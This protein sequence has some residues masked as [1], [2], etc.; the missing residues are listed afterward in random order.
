MIARRSTP[1]QYRDWNA[2]W[3]APFGHTV[4]DA[5]T[6][7]C[8]L[9]A[10][11]P[12]R[13][14]LFG[15]QHNSATRIFEYPWAFHTARL[16]PGYKVMDVGAG[17]SGFQFVLARSGCEVV[18][19]DP[20]PAGDQRWSSGLNGQQIW[21]TTDDHARL[22]RLLGTDVTLVADS[23]QNYSPD[24]RLFDR[25][26]CLSVLEH[27]DGNEANAMLKRMAELLVPGGLCV[28]TVDLFLD[29]KPFGVLDEN[30]WGRN[31]DLS[32]ALESVE[33]DMVHGDR[34]ELFGFPEFDADRVVSLLPEL[35]VSKLYPTMVQT[36][37]LRKP[38]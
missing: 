27:V 35:R 21:F 17:I 37:V 23:V 4:P 38:V 14:G 12:A 6:V 33:L 30:F 16:E 13:Y 18:N 25:I 1:Q 28:L 3:G 34:R 15:F 26:F 36:M 9:D 24:G 7:E 22:N 5:R 2:K 11:D 32:A 10:P 20:L 19:V 8:R 29:L 31:L